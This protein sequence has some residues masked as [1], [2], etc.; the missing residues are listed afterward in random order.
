[1]RSDL[2]K[3]NLKGKVWKISQT[4][5]ETGGGCLCPAAEKTECNIT[6]SLYDK[7]GNLVSSTDIDEDGKAAHVTKFIYNRFDICTS[8]ERYTGEGLLSREIPVLKGTLVTGLKIYDQNGLNNT[9][10]KYKY[11]GSQIAEELVC[12]NEGHTTSTI[13][14]E[15]DGGQLSKQTEKDASGNNKSISTFTRNNNND[16]T[17][18][19]VS[20][21]GDTTMYRIIFSY[22]YDKEGN[23]IKKTQMYNGE[24]INIVTRE[25]EYY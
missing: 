10:Y 19:R 1:M 17:E 25:I 13:L 16:I 2:Q 6:N 7:H 4:I 22:E 20:L 23:W 21:A 18:M 12:D 15:Y 14:N 5:H 9:T 8:I 24:I 11:A 3:D